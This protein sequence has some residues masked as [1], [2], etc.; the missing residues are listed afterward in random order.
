[1]GY[2]PPQEFEAEHKGAEGQPMSSQAL[3]LN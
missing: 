3:S 2:K 1:L